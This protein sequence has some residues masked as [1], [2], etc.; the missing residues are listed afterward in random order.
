MIYAIGGL[1]K[2]E[3][4]LDYS[5]PALIKALGL[6]RLRK[7]LL[8]IDFVNKLDAYGLC[9]GDRDYAKITIAKKCPV[10]GRKLG[11]TEMMHTLAH[12]MVHARQFLR[13]ELVAEG[14]WKWKGRNADGYEYDNQPWEKEAY[15]LET[16]LFHT[17]FPFHLPFN[18]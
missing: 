14:A 10:T 12:E 2:N 3:A 7:P 9:E 5:V 17:C 18:N 1:V 13:G 16:E 4:V 8:E 6:S 15:R 11:F